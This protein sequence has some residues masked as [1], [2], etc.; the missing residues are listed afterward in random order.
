MKSQY[1]CFPNTYS[2]LY[3]DGGTGQPF[4]SCIAPSTLVTQLGFLEVNVST[5]GV[6]FCS[7][8]PS[9]MPTLI[10]TISGLIGVIVHIVELQL[11][12]KLTNAGF[13][14]PPTASYT[15]GSPE[16]IVNADLGNTAFVE[17]V[18]PVD[19]RQFVQWQSPYEPW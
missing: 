9:K 11:P 18:D 7:A 5:F 16:M 13:P 19:F 12:Q 15:F 4:S 8:S 2:G 17:Y 1:A 10:T 6:N 3:F 14:L